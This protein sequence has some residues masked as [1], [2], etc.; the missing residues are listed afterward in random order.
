[1]GIGLVDINLP[2]VLCELY[3]LIVHQL[4]QTIDD[5]LGGRDAPFESESPFVDERC[6]GDVKSSTGLSRGFFSQFENIREHG[7]VSKIR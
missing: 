5:L 6:H 7:D 3:M 2:V 4:A 1:M